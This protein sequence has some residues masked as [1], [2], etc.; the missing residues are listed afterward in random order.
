MFD[1]RKDLKLNE[2]FQKMEWTALGSFIQ[3]FIHVEE[4]SQLAYLL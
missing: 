2:S 3:S 4:N 1:I